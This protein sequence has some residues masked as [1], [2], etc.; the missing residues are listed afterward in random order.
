MAEIIRPYLVSGLLIALASGLVILVCVYL[1]WRLSRPVLQDLEKYRMLTEAVVESAQDIIITIDHDGLVMLINPAGVASLRYTP[2]EI[3]HRDF[4]LLFDR[5][6]TATAKVLLSIRQRQLA[7]AADTIIFLRKKDGSIFPTSITCGYKQLEEGSLTTLVLHDL[8]ARKQ[9]ED[10]IRH[11][12]HKIIEIK[13]QEQDAISRE[14]HDTLG[15][16]LVWLKLQVQGMLREKMQSTEGKSLVACFDETIESMRSLSHS[17]SPIA[18]EKL[19]L[20]VM[21]SRLVERANQL[22]TAQVTLEMENLPDTFAANVTFHIFRIIQEALNNAMRHA[23]AANINIRC[24]RMAANL[25]LRISDDGE[26]FTADQKK[27]GLGL[28]LIA[29]R[30][31][32]LM[33][34]AEIKSSQGNGTEVKIELPVG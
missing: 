6:E 19:G 33:G 34:T 7:I 28:S 17:L 13:D 15:T 32:L 3:L 1:F 8:T 5:N 14:I 4:S 25:L 10:T 2:E 21:L 18:I 11:L 20:S 16:N 23:Q 31:K 30:A 26:G 9:T 22:G 12:T 24:S 27:D 29:E